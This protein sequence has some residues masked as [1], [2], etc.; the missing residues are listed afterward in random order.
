MLVGFFK[1]ICLLWESCLS[2][3]LELKIIVSGTQ[4][5][6]IGYVSNLNAY[7]SKP[8]DMQNMHN[9]IFIVT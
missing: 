2:Y 3:L 7:T 5:F 4:P 9:N 1:L 8:E 6:H